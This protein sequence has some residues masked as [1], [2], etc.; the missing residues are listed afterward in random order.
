M[1]H[2]PSPLGGWMRFISQI[3][4]WGTQIRPIR[5]MVLATGQSQVLQ[6]PIYVTFREGDVTSHE[7]ELARKSF[8]L[9]GFKTEMD[10]VTEVSPITRL[11]PFDTDLEAEINNWDA[12]TK[13]LVEEQLMKIANDQASDI[14]FVAP[15]PVEAPWPRYDDFD[16]LPEEL[17]A[18]LQE[19]GHDLSTVLRYEKQQQNRPSVIEMLEAAIE[20]SDADR[21]F[22]GA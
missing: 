7:V 13:A 10:E 22:I 19:D 20:T 12:E 8:A 5:E 17:L 11:S 15:T 18:K 9:R 14:I 2:P 4:R 16:G 1:T 21:E 3:K 6:E